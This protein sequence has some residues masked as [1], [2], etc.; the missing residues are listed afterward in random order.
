MRPLRS[1]L[2]VDESGVSEM[3]SLGDP[4]SRYLCLLGCAVKGEDYWRTVRPSLL[5]LKAR[6]F[7]EH[8]PT[9]VSLHR[10]HIVGRKGPFGVLKDAKR[11]VAFDAD[12][13]RTYAELPYILIG[14]VIDKRSHA[15][16]PDRFFDNPYHW[17]L[18]ML[19]ERYCKYLQVYGRQGRVICEARSAKKDRALQLAYRRI[20]ENGTPH[21]RHPA[22]FFTAVLGSKEI[23]FLPK[24]PAVAGLEIADG[25]VRAAKLEILAE[26]GRVEPAE[27]PFQ[28]AVQAA[29]GPKWNR[30]RRTGRVKGY[31]KAFFSLEQ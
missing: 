25:L 21:Y 29:M 16:Y 5:A 4:H 27:E 6:Q 30:R 2:F 19:L 11:R 18:A 23:R 1:Y 24:I 14:V 9:T 13:L 22:L 17:A 8:D 12:I 10:E 15:A 20:L 28:I 26:N 31:G 3:G 7:P